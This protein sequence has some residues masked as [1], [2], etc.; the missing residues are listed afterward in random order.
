MKLHSHICI[1]F[2]IHSQKGMHIANII[3]AIFFFSYTYLL[4]CTLSFARI[5]LTSRRNCN[6]QKELLNPSLQLGRAIQL[7]KCT[8]KKTKRNGFSFFPNFLLMKNKFGRFFIRYSLFISLIPIG[9]KFFQHQ[10]AFYLG[11]SI[12]NS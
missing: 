11:N 8:Y 1:L 4:V 2:C 5:E 6:N 7:G 10:V 3:K 9:S 12:T